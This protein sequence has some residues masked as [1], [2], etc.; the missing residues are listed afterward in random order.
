MPT[1]KVGSR[2]SLAMSFGRSDMRG[3]N[4]VLTLIVLLAL[5]PAA[6]A[7]QRI[8]DISSV[9]GMRDN[10]LI[11]YGLVVGLDG[12]GDQTTQT[13]FTVQSLQNMLTQLGVQLPAGTQ[14]QLKN[15][16]GVIVNARLNAFTKP[17]QTVDVTVSSI[18]NATSLRGGTLLMTPLKGPDGKVYGV[19][20]GNLVV[21]GF[22]AEGADGSRITF[23]V[24]S[25][26]RIPD[27]AI[28]ERAVPT[29]LGHGDSIHLNL[30]E[31]DFGTAAE[32]AAAINRTITPG[33][34]TALDPATVEVTAPPGRGDRVAF[35]AN[36][37][38]VAVTPVM[39][40]A[41]IVI[42]SRTG[43]VVIGSNVRVS[44]AAVSHGGL[45]VTISEAP[46]VVQPAP[47]SEGETAVEPNS[48]IEIAEG[49]GRMF[50]FE[51]GT[52][53]NE[54]VD[55]VNQVGAA[56]GDLMAILEALKQAGALRAEFVVI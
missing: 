26:G 32:I 5:T 3:W 51:G 30:H 2:G 29:S 19:A 18:G 23:N 15:V 42:N 47:F 9:A 28:V 11:G 7:A 10:Q 6:E 40:P 46:A 33:L 45:T 20:Q 34:A 31:P 54:V 24:P 35:I 49:D 1:A 17:G 37:E 56:P 27:G 44:P 36:L 50:L 41:R 53:L 12:T 13:P 52:T 43:T 14:L 4:R 8:K 21:G 39:P 25:A 55:A 22:G 38:N 16:A 48:A